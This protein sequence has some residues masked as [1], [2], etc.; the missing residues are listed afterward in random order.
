MLCVAT[1]LILAVERLPVVNGIVNTSR[2]RRQ[3]QYY[4]PCSTSS[5][6]SHRR[7]AARNIPPGNT[8]SCDVQLSY[9]TQ[10]ATNTLLLGKR[11]LFPRREA[12]R[13]ARAVGSLAAQKSRACQTPTTKRHHHTHRH[14]CVSIGCCTSQ[15]GGAPRA[16]P[17]R[18]VDR[19]VPEL[20]PRKIWVAAKHSRPVHNHSVMAATARKDKLSHNAR[21]Q[22]HFTTA[23]GGGRRALRA[24][25]RFRAHSM[26]RA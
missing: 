6:Q 2:N 7:G 1:T 5:D 17:W 4:P 21:L 25:W 22:Q 24:T 12:A 8:R 14:E 26:S 19:D 18:R 11:R 9:S 13:G 15:C 23:V 3:R 16:G 20:R 10:D